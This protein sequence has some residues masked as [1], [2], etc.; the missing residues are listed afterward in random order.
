M[1]RHL[2]REAVQRD[3]WLFANA[4]PILARPETSIHIKH[5]RREPMLPLGPLPAM[6]HPARPGEDVTAAFCGDPPPGRSAL[7]KKLRSAT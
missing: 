3:I 4:K 6:H 7:D 5:E 2:R 1:S